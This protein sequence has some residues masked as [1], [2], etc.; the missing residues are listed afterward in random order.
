MTK[1]TLRGRLETIRDLVDECLGELDPGGGFAAPQKP[2]GAKKEPVK[3]IVVQIIN[4]V[5]DC[6][7]ADL[8]QERVLDQRDREGKILLPFFI[9][10]KYFGNEWLTS[11]MIEKITSNLEIKIS[12]AD[13]SIGMKKYKKYLESQTVRKNGQPTPYRMNRNGVKRFEAIINA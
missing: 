6:D 3:D 2:M 7:E 1:G 13:A 12:M 5:S 4:K 9:S 10:H 8:I 11:G